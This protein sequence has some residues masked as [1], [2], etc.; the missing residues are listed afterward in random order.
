[1]ENE[2]KTE[3]ELKLLSDAELEAEIAL[4][5]LALVEGVN[6]IYSVRRDYYD[7]V[8]KE[9]LSRLDAYEEAGASL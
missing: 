7:L 9:L 5:N 1:M 2:M 8:R 3:K 6:N 4:A